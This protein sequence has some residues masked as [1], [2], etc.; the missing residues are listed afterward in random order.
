[1]WGSEGS[2][3]RESAIVPDVAVMRKTVADI[4][5]LALLHILLDGVELFLFGDLRQMSK[6][7]RLRAIEHFFELPRPRHDD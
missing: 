3:L 1:M 5:K 2:H 6:T 7:E 4:A